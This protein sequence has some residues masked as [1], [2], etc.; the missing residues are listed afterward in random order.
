MS[1]RDAGEGSPRLLED[2]VYCCILKSA[3]DRLRE[4]S[5]RKRLDYQV[6]SRFLGCLSWMIWS[7]ALGMTKREKFAKTFLPATETKEIG[8][9]EN[10]A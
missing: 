4:E 9:K 3:Q 7:R 1:S 5:P 10:N 6:S 8:G 2:A